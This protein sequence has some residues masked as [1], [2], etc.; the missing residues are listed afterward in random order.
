MGSSQL[1]IYGGYCEEVP[2]LTI[3]NREVKL[4]SADGTGTAGRVGRRHFFFF[5]FSKDQKPYPILDEAFFLFT[6]HLWM[7]FITWIFFWPSIYMHFYCII[8]QPTTQ[9]E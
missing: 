7:Y 6:S 5:A 4:L 1:K 9:W 8:C 2:P 3:P